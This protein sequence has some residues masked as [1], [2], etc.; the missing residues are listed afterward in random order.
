MSDRPDI[1]I[2]SIDLG[3]ENRVSTYE[4]VRR[5]GVRRIEF[6]D[7]SLTS[8]PGFIF[9][10]LELLRRAE[11]PLVWRCFG[12]V[13]DFARQPALAADMLRAGCQQVFLGIESIHDQILVKMRKGYDRGLIEQGLAALDAARLPVHANFI[14]GFPGETAQTVAE[15]AAFI[16]ASHFRSV[17]LAA[18]MVPRIL[19]A[20]ARAEP[21]LFNHL[22]G[23]S[24]RN[25]SH[26]TMDYRQAWRLARRAAWR[27][28][29]RQMYPLAFLPRASVP[30]C[31]PEAT[32]PV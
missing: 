20:Q 17:Y 11:L 29:L 28:N 7:S 6:M 9:E 4:D 8:E 30:E 19:F 2:R 23:D 31:A 24:P 27:I 25:W 32:P 5:Y 10:F 22:R 21:E 16:S 18:L 1:V 15:T 14:I 26:D 12:R 3:I 13:D